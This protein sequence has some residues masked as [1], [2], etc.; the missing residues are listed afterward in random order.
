MFKD[1]VLKVWMQSM[2][3]ELCAPK[4]KFGFGAMTFRI[5]VMT[6]RNNDPSEQKALK[7]T[8]LKT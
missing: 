1:G 2:E 5:G 3:K 6:L 8:C 4:A 7:Q